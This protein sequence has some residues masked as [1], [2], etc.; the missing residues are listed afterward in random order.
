MKNLTLILGL[1]FLGLSA[2]VGMSACNKEAPQP[3][4]TERAKK[5][6]Y[7][8]PMHPHILKDKPGQCPICGMTLVPV[9]QGSVA[10]SQSAGGS[11]VRIDPAVVQNIGVR[12][13]PVRRKILSAEIRLDGKVVADESR[14]K[15]VTARVMGYV[16]KLRAS[17]TGQPVSQGQVLLEL[18][19]P[20]LLAAQE[21]F[22]Q[23]MSAGVSG[24]VLAKSARRRLL[25]WGMPEY[26]LANLEKNRQSIR[27]VPLISPIRGVVMRK[28]VIEGQNV[29][30]GMEM[31]QIVDLSRV[32]IT[33][34]VFQNDLAVVKVGSSAQVRLRNLPGHDFTAKV[35]FV[36]PEMDPA[37]RTVEIRMELPNTPSRDLKPEMFAEVVLRA[38]GSD[39]ILVVPEQALIRT[40]NRDVALVALGEGRYQ[41]RDVRVG[42]SAG[43]NVEILAGLEEGETLVTSAQ[44]LIDSES[45]LRAAVEQ[46]RAA[47]TLKPEGGNHAGHQH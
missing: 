27:R 33:A 3:A 2:I 23:A 30:P 1:L 39:S 11:I 41:P 20:D 10:D 19:S 14:I 32:W 45:N 8:C 13:E 7:Q 42:R 12:T 28:N 25:G 34:R 36:S 4:V 46:L 38:P 24:E 37:T 43:G 26:F 17:I 47:G 40:G 5:N 21:E 29:M 31:F 18:Y 9:D 6:L 15:S 35:F 16:E 22:I 44:F